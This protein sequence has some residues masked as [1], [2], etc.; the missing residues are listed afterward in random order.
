MT[1]AVGIDL[2]TTNSC[3]VVLEGGNP[4]VIENAEGDRTINH[5]ITTMIAATTIS[6]TAS[7]QAPKV[8][9]LRLAGNSSSTPQLKSS[10]NNYM[11]RYFTDKTTKEATN[12]TAKESTTTAAT[13]ATAAKEETKKTTW[14]NNT[15]C[16]EQ[17]VPWPDGECP[18]P[19]FTMHLN[20]PPN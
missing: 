18:V 3:V 8:L 11:K 14:W 12:T 1:R 4:K 6:R 15:T 2:G 7:S 17:P 5:C 20:L 16:G 10:N 19:P 9:R 13:A